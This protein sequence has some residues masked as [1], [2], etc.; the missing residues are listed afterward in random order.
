[1]RDLG[2][3]TSPDSHWIT[4]VSEETGRFEL[5]A[6]SFP[7][8]GRKIQVSQNGASNEWWTRDGRQLVF[9]DD[10]LQSLWRVDV[11]PGQTLR[12]GGKTTGQ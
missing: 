5:F 7:E 11:E 9:V 8:P 6:L 12:V 3:K 10:K 1:M 2:G 4:Y